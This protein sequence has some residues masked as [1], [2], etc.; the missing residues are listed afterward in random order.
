M[1]V[2]RLGSEFPVTVGVE[3]AGTV[4]KLGSNVKGVSIGERVAFVVIGSGE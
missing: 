1:P 4:E 3:A 2:S